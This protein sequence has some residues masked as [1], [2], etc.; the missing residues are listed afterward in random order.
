MP[1]H[2]I[3]TKIAQT[4][5]FAV[6][7]M[8]AHESW[9][10][11][12]AAAHNGRVIAVSATLLGRP[13]NLAWRVDAAKVL[14]AQTEST[15]AADVTLT[16]MPSVYGAAAQLPFDMASIMRHVRI[17]GDAGLAEWVNRLAQQLRPDVWEDLSGLIGDAPTQ[18]IAQ[19][20]Q[21][22]LN[23]LK[24]AGQN[25]TA[26]AQYIA[27]D[28]HPIWVRHA[29]LDDFSQDAQELRYAVDRLEQRVALLKAR[30]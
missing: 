18:F 19:G 20:V 3:E 5:A 11:P 7:R 22:M 9:V 4:I 15:D 26:Q 28:E 21:H 16:L 1:H 10:L 27:L 2:F 25:L 24:Q 23:R 8:A 14:C 30:S 29:H 13:L 17:S 12:S 6:Q